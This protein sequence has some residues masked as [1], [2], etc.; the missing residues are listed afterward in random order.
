M[1]LQLSP[2]DSIS[3][4]SNKNHFYTLKIIGIASST[5]WWKTELSSGCE[6]LVD[7]VAVITELSNNHSTSFTAGIINRL[8]F[9]ACR[10]RD[11]KS[12]WT[13]WHPKVGLNTGFHLQKEDCSVHT[14][15]T[16]FWM[17]IL[18][19]H[20]QCKAWVEIGPFLWLAILQYKI[21]ERI[22]LL[23]RLQSKRRELQ[24]QLKCP[25][26]QRWPL[27]QLGTPP[28]PPEFQTQWF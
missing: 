5:I 23:N 10:R 24:K 19:H 11:G 25:G 27:T 21:R 28:S 12:L 3:H 9:S 6:E 20:Y 15:H 18:T 17:C 26:K 4:W 2:A 8:S 22:L 14:E 1:H 16:Y 7:K 13:P